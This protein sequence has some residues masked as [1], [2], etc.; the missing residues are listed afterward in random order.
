MEDFEPDQATVM[1]ILHPYLG[2]M[3]P[4]FGAAV[5]LHNAETSARARAELS[6]SAVAHNINCHAWA[7]F[8]REFTD[9]PGFHFLKPGGNLKVLNIRDELVLRPKKVDANGRHQNADTAQQR[10]FDSNAD[11]PGI[12]PAAARVIVGYQPDEAFSSV[13]RVT[14]RRPKARWVA[15]IVEIDAAYSWVDITPAELP[16]GRRAAH[17]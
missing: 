12:H 9:E 10:A 5:D 6:S 13:I 15:Q 1:A 17:G 7:G 3:F 11:L 14:V 4:I 2:R 16:L 8:E